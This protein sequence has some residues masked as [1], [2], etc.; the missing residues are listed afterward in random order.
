LFVTGAWLAYLFFTASPV[1]GF[2]F[3]H[4]ITFSSGWLLQHRRTAAAFAGGFVGVR[5]TTFVTDA[6]FHALHQGFTLGLFK[7]GD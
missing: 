5:I 3:A 1:A 7:R 4:A 2:K 6:F